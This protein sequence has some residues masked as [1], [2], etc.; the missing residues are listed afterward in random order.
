MSGSLERHCPAGAGYAD[1]RP[2]ARVGVCLHEID[3]GPALAEHVAGYQRIY[4]DERP[5]ETIAWAR[6]SNRYA[7]PPQ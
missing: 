5:H 7:A 4:N 3:D 2:G 6:P 1:A